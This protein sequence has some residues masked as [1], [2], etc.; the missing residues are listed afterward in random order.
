MAGA[1]IDC[2]PSLNESGGLFLNKSII[3]DMMF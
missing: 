2:V 3:G 1:L